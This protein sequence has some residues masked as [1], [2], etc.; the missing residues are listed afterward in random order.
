MAEDD[1]IA[2]MVAWCV[3][4]ENRVHPGKLTAGTKNGGFGKMM[5]SLPPSYQRLAM[6][7]Y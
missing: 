5:V 6:M 2:M 4:L 1:E 7:I 3:F